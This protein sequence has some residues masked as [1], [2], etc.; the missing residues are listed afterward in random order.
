MPI[1]EGGVVY[2]TAD[3]VWEIHLGLAQDF[4]QEGKPF[5]TVI[6]KPAGLE[7]AVNQPR[8]T[9]GGADLYPGVLEKAAALAR[10]IICGHVFVDG[11]KRTGMEAAL[12]F[13][14]LNGWEVRLTKD[15]YVA[16]ALDVAGARERGK[17]P[18]GVPEIA[19]R[20]KSGSRRAIR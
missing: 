2:L 7:A 16:L 14:E 20:L 10:G 5:E 17:E 13:L 19:E 8:Q 6:L 11:N 4:A 18:I 1:T 9:F 3:D 15:Q 12:V